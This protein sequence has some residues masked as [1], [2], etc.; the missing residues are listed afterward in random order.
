MRKFL[1]VIVLVALFIGS[2]NLKAEDLLPSEA[3]YKEHI[4]VNEVSATSPTLKYPGSGDD[5]DELGG[6]GTGQGGS[7]GAP[8]GD[9]IIP[10]LVAGLCYGSFLLFRRR[11]SEVK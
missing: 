10:I 2:T 5:D 4:A 7:V 6:T 8:I 3:Y 9:A 11:Q 1:S